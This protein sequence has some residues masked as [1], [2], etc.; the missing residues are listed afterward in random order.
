MQYT[1][2]QGTCLRMILALAGLLALTA[3]ASRYEVRV[4]AIVAPQPDTGAKTYFLDTDMKDIGRDDLYFQEF[5]AYLQQPLATLGYKPA[6]DRDT[7]QVIIAFNYGMSEG[8]NVFYSVSRPMYQMTGGETLSYRETKTDSGGTQTVTTGTVYI[9]LQYHY[10]GNTMETD[11]QMLY[12]GFFSLETRTKDASSGK[13][14]LWKI[15]AKCTSSSNDLR[16]LMPLMM[17][18][19]APYFNRNTGSEQHIMMSPART[20]APAAPTPAAK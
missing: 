11:S 6:A 19:A 5:A 20:T 10:V 9:P 8:T 3:C 16:L 1:R 17:Q 12:T 2:H 15:T 13:L 14:P 18:A 4:D 7:A